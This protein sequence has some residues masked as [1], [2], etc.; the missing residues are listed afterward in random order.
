MLLVY[1]NET[2]NISKFHVLYRLYFAIE[3][4]LCIKI[5]STIV[6]A[7]AYVLYPLGCCFYG[8]LKNV[9]FTASFLDDTR[10]FKHCV[11]CTGTLYL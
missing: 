6:T 1:E 11:K 7:F 2:M 10:K 9:E 4:A 3:N 8:T 5:S